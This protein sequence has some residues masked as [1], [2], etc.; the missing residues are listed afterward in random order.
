MPRLKET[1]LQIVERNRREIKQ[2]TALRLAQLAQQIR[3]KDED[4]DED[5]DEDD[6]KADEDTLVEDNR[7]CLIVLLFILL[8]IL[9]V[10]VHYRLR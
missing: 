8:A 6:I 5:S 7:L 2:R 1:R 9:L 10:V 4:S 3:H